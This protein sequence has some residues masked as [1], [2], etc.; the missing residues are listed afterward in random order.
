MKRLSRSLIT[1]LLVALLA[2]AV[3]SCQT[4]PKVKAIEPAA[5][6]VKPVTPVTPPVEEVVAEVPVEKPVV[7][8][9]V[10]EVVAPEIAVRKPPTE[11]MVVKSNDRFTEF[12][13]Y[14]AHTNDALGSLD[15]GIGYAKLATGV[16]F[17]RSLTNKTL[18]LDA[19]NV[20][21]GSAVVEKFMGEPAGVLLDLLGYDAVAP[22]P[23]DFA[24]GS[25]Y[26]VEAARF[27]E[28]NAAVKVLSANVLNARGEWVFQPYQLYYYNGFVVAVAGVTA[29]PADTRGLS[30]L[31]QEIVDSAQ[32]AVDLVREVA[33]FVVVLGN[34][35][36]VEG[37][38]SE[39]IAQNVKG[40][41]L[42]IDGK[43]AMAPAGGKRVGDTV[44]VNAGERL[45]SVGLVEVHV[46][47]NKVTS[48]TPLRI[49][50]ADVQKPSQSALAQWAGIDY[51]P[52]DAEVKSYIDY[53]KT[54]Y[55]KV[56]KPVEV[57]VPEK[58][59]VEVAKPA[60]VVVERKA[61]TKDMV[62]KSNDR[63]TEFDL[64]IA[65]TNDALGSLD[66]GIGYAKLA[67]GVKFGRSLTNKTLLLDAGN[68]ASGSA[69]VEKFMGEPA[70]VLLDLLGY[71]AVAPGPADF[72]YGSDYL[73][74]AARFAEA[75]AALKVLSANVLNARGEW[76]FQPYQLY[77][78]NGFVVAVAGVTAPAPAR[79]LS[80]LNQDIV[81][82]AQYAV[83]LVREVA[84][85]VVVLGN[86]GNVEGI[87]SEV[88]AQNVKGI[89]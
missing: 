5:P 82:S 34:I 6:V 53:V 33:D 74:E 76:V 7:T 79:G 41:D 28:A 63:F 45:S 49:N 1:T 21:S 26:L 22:G 10:E 23:A 29:P 19:G 16:K 86:I 50:A 11:E 84:D 85:F 4:T 13:L 67:T 38:T 87:T 54:T 18:L 65:H 24:Y 62:V 3:I 17:G 58:V 66:E 40:I 57:K 31:N 36:N 78:Y 27:A 35:G 44:I 12:D 32:Y 71:D 89:D 69:I 81:D 9:P 60:P 77:Y 14:I 48:V 25:D 46:K 20:A 68:A 88:I 59:V 52:E 72:A 2:F 61:P 75:N 83:D 80:F 15:E 8:P 43:G 55:A 73:I 70:G 42:I 64:Y 47:D 51:V 37:I 30:F 39:V 56:T